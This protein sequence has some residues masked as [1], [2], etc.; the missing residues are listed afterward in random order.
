MQVEY[1][2]GFCSRKFYTV[3]QSNHQRRRSM[4]C[5]ANVW[6][7][8]LIL[9]LLFYCPHPTVSLRTYFSCC[10]SSIDPIYQQESYNVHVAPVSLELIVSTMR[11]GSRQAITLGLNPRLLPLISVTVCLAMP[12][13]VSFY[14]AVGARIFLTL[15]LLLA[16]FFFFFDVKVEYIYGRGIKVIY[17]S[18]CAENHGS[19]RNYCSYA[20]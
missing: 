8:K 15:R 14:S 4:S 12:L 10:F 19:W 2:D 11:K 17:F 7:Q 16:F 18:N 5:N 9:F 3:A 1:S 20:L 13:G 6:F